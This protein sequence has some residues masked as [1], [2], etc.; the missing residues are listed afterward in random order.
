MGVT[1][2]HRKLRLV[3][4]GV[5]VQFQKMWGSRGGTAGYPDISVKDTLV[6]DVLVTDISVTGHFGN[7][8]FR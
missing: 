8:T 2:G 4:G 5:R 6:M 7:K 3:T 1:R